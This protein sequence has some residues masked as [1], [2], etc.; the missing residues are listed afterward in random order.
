MQHILACSA[1]LVSLMGTCVMTRV[2]CMHVAAVA[3]HPLLCLCEARWR[4][5]IALCV[6]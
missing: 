5:I 1:W 3:F 6:S 2:A 4:M